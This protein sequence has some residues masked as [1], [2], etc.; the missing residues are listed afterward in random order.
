VSDVRGN[1]NYLRTTWHAEDSMFVFSVWNGDVCLGAVRVP[2]EDAA[3]MV[4]LLMDGMIDVVAA[5]PLPLPPAHGTVARRPRPVPTPWDELK[6][7]LTAWARFGAKKA[8]TLKHLRL[9][10]EPRTSISPRPG[11]PAGQGQ[12]QRTSQRQS[13]SPRLYPG[14]RITGPHPPAPRMA[15]SRPRPGGPGRSG[16][17][18]SG[19]FPPVPPAR[20]RSA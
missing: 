16:P 3:D 15:A 11:Q 17:Q 10:T 5:G 14:T 18:H 13:A 2:V 7:Q 8:A 6:T 1:G 19:P 4:S 9:T 12:A 20:R